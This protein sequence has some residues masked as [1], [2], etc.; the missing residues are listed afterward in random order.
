MLSVLDVI[1]EKESSADP[2]VFSKHQPKMAS[3]AGEAQEVVKTHTRKQ[4]EQSI[5]A[6]LTKDYKQET[7]F[8]DSPAFKI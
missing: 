2:S 1:E 5:L 3:S 4:I 6:E 7:L 8:T